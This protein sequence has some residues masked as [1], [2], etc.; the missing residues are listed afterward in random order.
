VRRIVAESRPSVVFCENVPP[1]LH[2]GFD[3]VVSDMG[4]LGYEV[5]A[6]VFT[7]W[8]IGAPHVRER[9]FWVASNA[10]GEPGA[11]RHGEPKR[12]TEPPHWHDAA[13]RRVQWW[14]DAPPPICSGDDD[15]PN[16][17]DRLAAIGNAV[18][19]PVAARAFV[20]LLG[21]L[22]G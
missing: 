4:E 12:R 22:I 15:V 8:A 19:P 21:E 5:A 14:R 3:E 17:V 13:R 20:V 10:N 9:L 7:A 1:H 16:R 18:V 2:E 6:G 11:K